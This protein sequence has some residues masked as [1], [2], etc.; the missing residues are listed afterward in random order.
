MLYYLGSRILPST[1][2]LDL[3]RTGRLGLFQQDRSSKNV[4]LLVFSG[5][6]LC[7]MRVDK[8]PWIYLFTIAILYNFD[9]RRS[10]TGGMDSRQIGHCSL[11]RIQLS[12]Q[13]LWKICRHGVTM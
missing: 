1:K 5:A 7:N 4:L 8:N 13:V 6:E 10:Y 12:R 3:P 9:N 2:T 11:N